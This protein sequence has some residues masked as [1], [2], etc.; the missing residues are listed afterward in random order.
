MVKVREAVAEGSEHRKNVWSLNLTG[1]WPFFKL[2]SSALRNPQAVIQP[3]LQR[4]VHR[5]LEGTA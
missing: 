5:G 1:T 4:G 2:S 3:C